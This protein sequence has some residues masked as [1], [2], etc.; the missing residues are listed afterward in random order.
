MTND[1][2]AADLADLAEMHAAGTLSPEEYTIASASVLHI[3]A[4]EVTADLARATARP[5]LPSDVRAPGSSG[6]ATAWIVAGSAL[7]CA[8]AVVVAFLVV[9][10]RTGRSANPT[11]GSPGLTPTSSPRSTEP[12]RA[13]STTAAPQEILRQRLM[14]DEPYAE[15]LVGWWVPQ[16]S[17]KRLGAI[18]DGVVYDHDEMSRHVSSLEQRFPGALLI[19]SG[20]YTSFSSPD[21]YV[22]VVP[23]PFDTGAA[24]IGWCVAQGLGPDD[25]FAKRL[26]HTL[27]P[28]NSTIYQ[29]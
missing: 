22:V 14:T 8:I 2:I 26:S 13:P 5:P 17:A 21:F 10:G 6:N 15:Q 29:S 7:L 9:S 27:D 20:N 1:D 12:S 19:W 25:C 3:P 23:T 24:A 11:A 18:V 4:S 28:T 16:V